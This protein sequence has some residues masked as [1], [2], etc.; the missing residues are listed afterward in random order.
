MNEHVHQLR[1]QYPE[2]DQMGTV[3]HSNY[4]K[5]FETARWEYFRELGLSYADIE[6]AGYMLPVTR[7]NMHFLRTTH[8]DAILRVHTRITG[9]KGVRIWIENKLYNETNELINKTEIE[10]A[11]VR[12]G[13]WKP[14]PPPEFA[15]NILTKL[16]D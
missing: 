9:L 11:F 12:K 5:Y 6:A 7:C 3:H 8:Y 4:L 13:S 10:L 16:I 15:T 2:T 14:C 1:V